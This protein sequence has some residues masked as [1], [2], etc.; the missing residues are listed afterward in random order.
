MAHG[1]EFAG[2][3]AIEQLA[4][5]VE[6]GERGYAFSQRDLIALGNVLVLVHVADVDVNEHIIGVQ[7]GFVGRVVEVDIQNLAIA[8]PIAAEIEDDALVLRSRGFESGR[9]IEASLLRSRI[10]FRGLGASGFGRSTG[11]DHRSSKEKGG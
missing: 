3:L 6:N 4:V 5:F 10:D 7:D 11:R 1:F 9:E 8:A 2:A